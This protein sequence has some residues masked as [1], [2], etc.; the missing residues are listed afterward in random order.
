MNE[1]SWHTEEV[2]GSFPEEQIAQA[3]APEAIKQ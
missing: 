1:L 3:L 2:S